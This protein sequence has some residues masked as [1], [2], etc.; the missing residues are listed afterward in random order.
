M[1]LIVAG[2]SF[3]DYTKVDSPYGKL[4][5]EKLGYEYIHEGAGCGSN[6]RIWRRLTSMVLDGIITSDDLVIVQYTERTRQEFYTSYPQDNAYKGPNCKEAI[7]VV[8]D[9]T[10]GGHIIRFKWGAHVWQYNSE[11][12]QLFKLYEDGFLSIDYSNE[13]FRV[14]HYNFQAMLARNNIKCIFVKTW[15]YRYNID[16]EILLEFEPYVFYDTT[17]NEEYNLEPGDVGHLSQEG[18]IDFSDRLY[19]HIKQVGL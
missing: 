11:E 6:Q 9:Y 5:A 4:L 13:L 14:N 10:D 8:E 7:R 1:K 16:A 12:K 2:C 3:S 15:R 19:T 18:H 17:V